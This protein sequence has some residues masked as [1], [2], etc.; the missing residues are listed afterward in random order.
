[1]N[2]YCAEYWSLYDILDMFFANQEEGIPVDPK[3][4]IRAEAAIDK[5]K[6]QCKECERPDSPDSMA[7]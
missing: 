6:R 3:A 2:T 4:I 1:M 7:S 5:H